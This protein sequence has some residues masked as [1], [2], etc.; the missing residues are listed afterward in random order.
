MK[1]N[2]IKWYKFLIFFYF[3]SFI[4][5]AILCYFRT[6]ETLG[7]LCIVAGILVF[8]I[9]WFLI[10]GRLQR[11]LKDIADGLDRIGN[12]LKKLSNHFNLS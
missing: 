11:A 2:K 12:S 9:W 3:L 5:G 6:Y 1:Q 7:W 8:V 10:M 4:S